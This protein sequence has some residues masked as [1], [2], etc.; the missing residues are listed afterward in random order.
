[1]SVPLHYYTSPLHHIAF[2]LAGEICT[3]KVDIIYLMDSSGSIGHDD[4]Q[5]QKR[6][7]NDLARIFRIGPDASRAGVVTYHDFPTVRAHFP[8]YDDPDL[9]AKAVSSI[10]QTRGRTRI[11]KALAKTSEMF[12][13]ARKGIP[14]VLIALTDGAQ[15][16]DPDAV[17]L[18]VASQPLRDQGVRVYALGVGHQ[19]NITQL[20]SMVESNS[21]VFLVDSF[22]EL[23]RRSKSIAQKACI[24]I[25][26]RKL[27]PCYFS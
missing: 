15:T 18:D 25:V 26:N 2:D 6:F 13:S 11:D 24:G 22:G 14:K 21:D 1:M 4:F 7:V 27:L 8:D 16:P 10:N 17:E 9:F 5:R 23:L 3:S 12:Q 19:I 20:R